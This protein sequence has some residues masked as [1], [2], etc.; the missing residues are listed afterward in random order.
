M[1]N[2]LFLL[3][4]LSVISCR[5]LQNYVSIFEDNYYDFF[6]IKNK[7][8]NDNNVTGFYFEKP[9]RYYYRDKEFGEILMDDKKK[10]YLITG[11]APFMIEKSFS[12]K[13]AMFA[14]MGIAPSILTD[15]LEFFNKHKDFDNVRYYART[16]S[17]HEIS[18]KNRRHF[19]ARLLERTKATNDF[20][21]KLNK[22]QIA[23]R[24]V[25]FMERMGF[26]LL[27]DAVRICYSP[28]I[29]LSVLSQEEL[30]IFG[31]KWLQK[32]AF[33]NWFEIGY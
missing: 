6:E 15:Y 16:I 1:K 31:F 25:D 18:E 9:Y 17:F 7:I 8:L 29:D 33:D 23:F 26:M 4:F 20:L 10:E 12:S 3:L 32:T 27:G 28:D 30:L 11:K 2:I 14:E 21:I 5:S 22:E 24:F 19:S 13:D